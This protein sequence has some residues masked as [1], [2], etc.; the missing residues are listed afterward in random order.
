M[1]AN[2]LMFYM[3]GFVELVNEPPTRDQW[4]YVRARVKEAFAVETF[5][6]NTPPAGIPPTIAPVLN[7]TKLPPYPPGVRGE[8]PPC[9]FSRR[10]D[11]A[12]AET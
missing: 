5:V 12:T 8:P 3:K 6:L 9:G 10:K 1:N 11:D 7:H 2:E 4:G